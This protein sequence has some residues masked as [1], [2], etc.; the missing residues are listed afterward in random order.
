MVDLSDQ[1]AR[2]ALSGCTRQDKP[3]TVEGLFA[4][5]WD[6]VDGSLKNGLRKYGYDSNYLHKDS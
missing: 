1:C 4:R 6:V 2:M 5:P 3:L